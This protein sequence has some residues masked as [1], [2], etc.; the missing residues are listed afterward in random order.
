M[1]GPGYW[2]EF[3]VTYRQEQIETIL[4]WL[5]GGRSGVVV[6][7][8]GAG[9][10]NLLGFLAGRPDAARPHLGDAVDDTCFLLL[11]ANRLPALTGTV[12]HRAMLHTLHQHRGCLPEELQEKVSAIY[13]ERIDSEDDLLLFGA[14]QDL[15]QVFCYTG[16]KR[17][18]WLLDRFDQACRHL[19]AQ[20]LNSLRALRDAFKIQ[21]C[22]VVATRYPLIRL[23]EDPGEIDEFYELLAA[24]T[25][26]VG[27]MVE[28]DAQWVARQ[29]AERLGA[30][31]AEK[32]V[33]RISS[34]TGRLPAFL[35]AGFTLL[36]SGE[37]DVET[38]EDTWQEQL[39]SRPEIQ[40]QCQQLWDDLT[41]AQQ[42]GLLGVMGG[43]PADSIDLDSLAG[44]Q[45]MGLVFE[46]AG[47]LRVFS[48]LFESFVSEVKGSPGV[49]I[50]LH[51]ETR[52]VWRGNTQ[53]PVS[54]TLKEDQLL[55]YFLEH[56]SELCTKDA[57][58]R[59][60]WPD[61]VLMEG[62]RDDRLA[63]LVKRLRE[64]IELDPGDPGYILTVH[65]Q[66]YRFVQPEG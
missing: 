66:G 8:S 7:M 63:Q 17:V 61:E 21:L 44:L 51:P 6:G 52:A 13:R 27:P 20:F 48:P 41:D 64:K 34:L 45:D 39:L 53:L 47:R 12:F 56:T 43:S 30:N 49:Q 33:A 11:D 16:G 1:S 24:N 60:V 22:F 19:D 28:R 36:A 55:S 25:C 62:V 38:D 18:V 23:R 29:M 3:P 46:E 35:K 5:R 54:L 31:F 42:V 65:G 50:R 9:K 40:R 4:N 26:W 15:H 2:S 37:L 14:L 10:S 32:D 59:A 58:I 57:L